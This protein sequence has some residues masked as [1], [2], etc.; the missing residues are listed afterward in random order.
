VKLKLH[1]NREM[2][3]CVVSLVENQKVYTRKFC[4]FTEVANVSVELIATKPASKKQKLKGIIRKKLVAVFEAKDHA[5]MGQRIVF[6]I[7]NNIF[8]DIVFTVEE[9]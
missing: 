6:G 7:L 3:R 8:K 9:F 2:Q 4:G 1:E 5:N